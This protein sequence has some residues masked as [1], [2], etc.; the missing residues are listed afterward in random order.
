MKLNVIQLKCSTSTREATS[1]LDD[2]LMNGYIFMTIF[3]RL[4]WLDIFKHHVQSVSQSVGTLLRAP[5]KCLKFTCK[6]P[7]VIQGAHES[8]HWKMIP[9]SRTC[10]LCLEISSTWKVSCYLVD[11]LCPMTGRHLTN[12]APCSFIL[13]VWVKEKHW[14]QLGFITRNHVTPLLVSSPV[15]TLY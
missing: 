8:T 9:V 4:G 15:S 13:R 2:L 10:L 3:Q 7:P 6:I 11:R 1:W 14:Q 5:V 12:T